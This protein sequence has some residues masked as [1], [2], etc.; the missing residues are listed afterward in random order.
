MS[1]SFFPRPVSA[2]GR[3]LL[4][5]ALALGGLSLTTPAQAQ[6]PASPVHLTQLNQASLRLRIANPSQQP[7]RVEVI[8][9]NTGQPLFTETYKAASYGHRF[10]FQNLP[11]G[12]YALLLKVGSDRYRYTV[13]VA[14][15]AAGSSLAIRELAT[16]QQAPALASAN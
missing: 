2:T 9:L 3:I 13:E 11:T 15:T 6:Q 5:G 14:T 12:R 8:H 16:R 10:D 4:L 7:S 1:S